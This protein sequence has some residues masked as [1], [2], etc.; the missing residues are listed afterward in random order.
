MFTE[1]FDQ[2]VAPARAK[3]Q[4]WRLILGIVLIVVIYLL[5]I[6]I[7]FG[8]IWAFV[9]ADKTLQF[10]NGIVSANTPTGMF[11]LFAS[12]LGAAIAPMLVVRL[13]HRRNPATLFGPRALLVSHFAQAAVAVIAVNALFLAVLSIWIDPVPN[14]TF[15]VWITLLPVT[16]LGLLVQTGAEELV[17]RGYLQQQLAARFRSPIFW[18]LLPSL[19][20][21]ALHYDP[22]TAGENTWL[23]VGATGLFALVAADLTRITG[24]LGAAWGFHFANNLWAIV[25]FAVDGHI[26]GLALYVTPYSANDTSILPMLIAGDMVTLVLFW[27]GLRHFLRR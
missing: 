8:V 2:F 15:S 16:I 18:M 9:G 5:G 24:S 26:T 23:I 6:A 13:L 20:F 19:G 22:A 4:I 3:P 7:I 11:L 27:L 12:F 17:F 25:L 10:A 1:Q 21:A 14:L